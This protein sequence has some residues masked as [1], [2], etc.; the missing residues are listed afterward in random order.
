MVLS[1]SQQTESQS[2]CTVLLGGGVLVGEGVERSH[3]MYVYAG[4]GWIKIKVGSGLVSTKGVTA[5]SVVSADFSPLRH[6]PPG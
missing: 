6:N 2:T 1:P 5:P 3:M 4:R